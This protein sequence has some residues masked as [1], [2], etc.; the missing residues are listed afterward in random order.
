MLRLPDKSVRVWFAGRECLCA[1]LTATL[2]TK[3]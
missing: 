3:Q 2:L 1:T